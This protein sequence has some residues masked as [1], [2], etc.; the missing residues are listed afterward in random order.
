MQQ[1]DAS[2]LR[3]VNRIRAIHSFN[4]GN[5]RM[6]RQVRAHL[7]TLKEAGLIERQGSRKVGRWVVKGA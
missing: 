1:K 3:K 6:G 7:A 2:R 4:D 5:G